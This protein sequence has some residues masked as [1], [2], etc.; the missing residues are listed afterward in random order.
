ML[1]HYGL[2]PFFTAPQ[3]L[4]DAEANAKLLEHLNFPSAFELVYK[5]LGMF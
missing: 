4:E 3:L 5:Q 2:N 1:G